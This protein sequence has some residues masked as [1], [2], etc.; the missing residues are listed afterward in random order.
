MKFFVT[1]VC[2]LRYCFDIFLE[3][4]E[5]KKNRLDIIASN[6]RTLQNLY[7]VT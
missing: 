5:K 3:K 7:G 4:K 2:R 6:I 1:W